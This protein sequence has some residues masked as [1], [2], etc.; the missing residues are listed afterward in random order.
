MMK[1][2]LPGVAFYHSLTTELFIK[3]GHGEPAEDDFDGRRMK[4]GQVDTLHLHPVF[5]S[6]QPGGEG[7]KGR[8]LREPEDDVS[9]VQEALHLL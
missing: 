6:R 5:S 3:L 8:L 7:A 1:D 4:L 2:G 9:G